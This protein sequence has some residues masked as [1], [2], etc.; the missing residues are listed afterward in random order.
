[1]NYNHLQ[2]FIILI[3]LSYFMINISTI[4]LLILQLII[5]VKNHNFFEKQHIFLVY[6]YT[7][8]YV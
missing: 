1:M 7:E 4:C 2:L 6:H 3:L 5:T 8:H